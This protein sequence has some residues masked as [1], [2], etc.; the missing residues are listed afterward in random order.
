MLMVTKGEF[1]SYRISGDG[2]GDMEMSFKLMI[3][4][5]GLESNIFER[6][7]NSSRRK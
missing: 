7:L 2:K 5:V 4:I 1:V 3:S 6:N